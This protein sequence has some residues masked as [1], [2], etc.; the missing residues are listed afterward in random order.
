MHIEYV[1]SWFKKYKLL[2]NTTICM[3]TTF[4]ALLTKLINRYT[5]AI[6]KHLETQVKTWYIQ[7]RCTYNSRTAIFISTLIDQHLLQ[8]IPSSICDIFMLRVHVFVVLNMECYY[9]IYQVYKTYPI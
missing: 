1:A 6:L 8:F 7:Y 4:Y 9:L 3:I 5:H 2:Q